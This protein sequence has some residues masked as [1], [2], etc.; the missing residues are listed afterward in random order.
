[1]TMRYNSGAVTPAN[2]DNV[3]LQSDANG[4]LKVAAGASTAD[5]GN[6]G[7]QVAAGVAVAGNPMI[8]GLEGRTSTA[9]QVSNGQSKRA[10]GTVDGRIIV[11]PFVIPENEWQYAAA[12]GGIS[13]TTTAVTIKAAAGASV[14]NYITA[15]QIM[16]EALGAA[17]ELAIR[18][19]AAGT[20]I[21][22][23]KIGTGGIV[24]GET[25]VFPTPLKG[26]ANTLLEVVT[27]TASVTGA[28]FF[29]AQGFVAP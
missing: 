22:R 8:I 16:S 13:N 14:R 11:K 6:V 24:G 17:T 5:I 21:W 25:V 12:A 1:M 7:G 29:N 27:L 15:I 2:G 20:V 3:D 4:N 23:T 10:V 18:D 9:G 28:V 19:G 26:T